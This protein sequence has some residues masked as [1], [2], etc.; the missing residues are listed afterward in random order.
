MKS[1]KIAL[2]VLLSVN[3][4]CYSQEKIVELPLTIQNGYGPFNMGINGMRTV[5]ENDENPWLNTY[6]KISSLPKGLT[7]M[8][9]GFIETDFRQSLYQDYLLGYSDIDLGHDTL[10]LSKTPL[11]TKIYFAFGK[12]S[13]GIIKVAVDANNNSDLSD[14]ALFTPIE[15]SSASI[16][17]VSLAQAHAVNV[18]FETFI[19]NKIVPV[20]VPLYILYNSHGNM[21]VYNFPQYATTQF[22]GT[23]ISV[24]SRNFSNLSYAEIEL[25][26]D[27]KNGEKV[28]REDI[29]RKNEFLEIE[30]EIYKI[31]GVNTNN[32]TL[33]LEKVDLP[34]NQLFST[35]IGYKTHPFQEEEFTKKT[36]ISLEDFKGK[37]VLLDFWA[38]WCA[39]CIA[40]LPHLK[41]LYSKTDRTKFEI[42][43]IAAHSTPNGIKRLIEQHEIGWSQILSNDIVGMYGITSFPT[44]IL[45]DTEGIIVAKNMS[46]K[47]LEEKIL[48]LIRD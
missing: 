25:A 17:D 45:L 14:D 24:S 18:T 6:Q 29:L 9:Y 2:I 3:I 33:V 11:K 43:G 44:T 31:I 12:N 21:C 32:N 15:M 38:E 13:E 7:D 27:L 4:L 16:S 47:E 40:K 19:N 34:K 1:K 8:K 41:E 10:N 42:I 26:L 46:G 35:Q 22:K 23:Q 5:S 37:Y 28:K 20:S 30:D 48:S 39:P 36:V